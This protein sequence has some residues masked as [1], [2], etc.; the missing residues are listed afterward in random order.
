VFL[1][2]SI[3]SDNSCFSLSSLSTVSLRSNTSNSFTLSILWTSLFWPVSSCFCI[4]FNSFSF[5]DFFI[6][7]ASTWKLRFS[8]NSLISWPFVS[9][10]ACQSAQACWYCAS[11]DWYHCRLASISSGM[12]CSTEGRVLSIGV[13]WSCP[14]SEAVDAG[15]LCPNNEAVDGVSSTCPNNEAVDGVSSLANNEAVKSVASWPNNEAVDGA[16]SCPDNAAVAGCC[17]CST[18]EILVFCSS[19]GAGT[20]V[21]TFNN[22]SCKFSMVLLQV[23]ME[24]VREITCCFKLSFSETVF[25]I[26]WRFAWS[27]DIFCSFSC[28]VCSKTCCRFPASDC[29]TSNWCLRS[30]R[31]VDNCSECTTFILSWS[32][33][34]LSSLYELL[35]GLLGCGSW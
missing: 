16:A 32:C 14:N 17:S 18:T 1:I 13:A 24:S 35:C 28:F 23:D 31:S 20:A 15:S 11:S 8:F 25:W 4:C 19:L 29:F 21:V 33:R 26:L 6:P 22:S 3:S 2:S 27:S 7:N 30:P 12:S 9:P 10:Q 34:F 5:S